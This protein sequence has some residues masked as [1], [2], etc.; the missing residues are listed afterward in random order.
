MLTPHSI[1]P[2][3]ACFACFNKIWGIPQL[4]HS[5]DVTL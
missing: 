1:I 4:L 3:D 2:G 5:E